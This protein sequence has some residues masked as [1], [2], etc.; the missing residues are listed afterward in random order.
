MTVVDER[1]LRQRLVQ[2]DL[3]LAF[4]YLAELCVLRLLNDF[5][6]LHQSLEAAINALLDVLVQLREVGSLLSRVGLVIAVGRLSV[7]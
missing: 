5:V 6:L 3:V 4:N 2:K 7:H 1:C